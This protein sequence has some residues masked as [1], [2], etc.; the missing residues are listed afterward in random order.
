MMSL[1]SSQSGEEILI[2]GNFLPIFDKMARQ[3]CRR[4]ENLSM[5]ENKLIIPTSL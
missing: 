3:S 5:K 4:G 1:F 2:F